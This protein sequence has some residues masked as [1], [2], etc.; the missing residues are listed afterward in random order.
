MR[1]NGLCPRCDQL[2]REFEDLAENLTLSLE[3]RTR[4]SAP[5]NEV[6]ASLFG[7]YYPVEDPWLGRSY[8]MEG[9]GFGIEAILTES[10]QLSG[11]R[12]VYEQ[13]DGLEL[14]LTIFAASPPER[15]AP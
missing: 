13:I 1:R 7:R 5:R 3:F 10:E 8:L 15:D 14:C 2:Y 12:P 11:R 9:R 6:L 4:L